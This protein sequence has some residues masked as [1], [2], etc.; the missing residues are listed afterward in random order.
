VDT[1][2]PATRA[3]SFMLAKE[4]PFHCFVFSRAG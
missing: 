4:R 1:D 3:T 2:T